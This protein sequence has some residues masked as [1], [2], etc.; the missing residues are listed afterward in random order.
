LPVGWLQNTIARLAGTAAPMRRAFLLA[1]RQV[2]TG[3]VR[4]P[5]CL[6]LP[7][8]RADYRHAA[9]LQKLPCKRREDIP[10]LRIVHLDHPDLVDR[11]DTDGQQSR[12]S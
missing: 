7:R 3:P 4:S 2:P 6:A 8:S 10:H 11:I 1:Y 5:A 9:F 12:L